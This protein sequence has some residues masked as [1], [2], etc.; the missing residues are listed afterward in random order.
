MSDLPPKK[1]K[2]V[3]KNDTICETMREQQ[4]SIWDESKSILHPKSDALTKM[5]SFG[6]VATYFSKNER[7]MT[8]EEEI[9]KKRV[10]YASRAQR[11]RSLYAIYKKLNEKKEKQK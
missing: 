10:T 7:F 9:I 3:K 4:S 2:S 6:S 8:K 5:F 11:N 1:P